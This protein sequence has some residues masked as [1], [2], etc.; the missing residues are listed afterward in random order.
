VRDCGSPR[1]RPR[2]A[3]GA[4]ARGQTPDEDDVADGAKDA[5][6]LL[7]QEPETISA[8]VRTSN[9]ANL[10]GFLRSAPASLVKVALAKVDAKTDLGW[11]PL[12]PEKEAKRS[13]R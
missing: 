12:I 5:G 2:G 13:I 1:T 10:V 7:E 4:V 11:T 9:A 8:M 3:A 6:A